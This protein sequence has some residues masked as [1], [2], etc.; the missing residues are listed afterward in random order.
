LFHVVLRDKNAQLVSTLLHE[1]NQ[2]SILPCRTDLHKYSAHISPVPLTKQ[3]SPIPLCT[4]RS[5]SGA[6]PCARHVHG[7]LQ[8]RVHQTDCPRRN[9]ISNHSSACTAART[10]ADRRTLWSRVRATCLDREDANHN[11]ADHD[12]HSHRAGRDYRDCH[13]QWTSETR[14]G[15]LDVLYREWRR[16]EREGKDVWWWW[17]RRG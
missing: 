14:Q 11:E 4:A 13:V 15:T 7:Q 10:T 6:L 1:T 3:N 8:Y 16:C 12:P 17:R 9:K 5:L 2:P